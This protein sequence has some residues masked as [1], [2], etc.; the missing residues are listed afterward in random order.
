[1]L[2][3]LSAVIL[4]SRPRRTGRVTN[5]GAA[6]KDLRVGPE[7]EPDR[8][9]DPIPAPLQPEELPLGEAR[10]RFFA[11]S[12]FDADGGYNKRWVR[13]ESKPIPIF[14]PNIEPRVRAVKLHD[15]HHIVTGYRTDWVGEAEIGAWEISAGCGKYWAAWALNAGAFA[16][17]LAAAP[18][19]TFRAFVR[20]RRSRS[21]YHEHFRDELLEETVGGMRG[22]L[23]LDAD[24]AP[25]RRDVA[26]FAGWS[27]A[28]VAYHATAAAIGL[29]AVLW[30]VSLSRRAR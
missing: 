26:A 21:L 30:V 28:V 23:G 3:R 13:I 18:R 20:G 11:E 25:T 6:T 29:R 24:V 2:R 8:R 7:R 5:A 27:A 17:G 22:R 1:M 9:A 10:A 12:G 14:F 4:R 16:F 19:R 15:L